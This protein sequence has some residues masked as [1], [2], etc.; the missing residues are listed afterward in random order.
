MIKNYS[1]SASLKLFLLIICGFNFTCLIAQNES[2]FYTETNHLGITQNLVIDYNANGTD[3]VD[4]S[5]ALQNAIDYLT[6]LPDGG[7]IIIPSGTFYFV[8]IDMKS[9]VHLEIDANTTII[10][11]A[12]PTGNYAIFNFG[13]NTATVNNVSVRSSGG[14]FTIDLSAVTNVNVRVFRCN[15]VNNFLLSD[16]D[17]LDNN[18]KFASTTMGFTEHNGDYFI[19]T[20]GVVKNATTQTAHYGYGLVQIQAGSNILYKNLS[21][22]GGITLRMESGYHLMN[23]LRPPG[24]GIFDVYGR[25]I[26]CE[27]GSAA[28]SFSPHTM[29]NGHVDV[30]GVTAVNCGF[31]A[32]VAFGFATTEQAALGLVPGY[33][34]PTSVLKNVNAVY[35]TTAQ[36]KPKHYKYMPCEIQYLNSTTLNPDGES[37]TGPS[38]NAVIYDA[39]GGDPAEGD[40]TVTITNV[41]QNGFVY[42]QKTVLVDEDAVNPSQCPSV[43]AAFTHTNTNQTFNFDGSDSDDTN[44]FI[45]SWY[46]DFGDG[47]TGTGEFVSHT[48]AASGSYDVHLQVTDNVGA[49]NSMFQTVT[50]IFP[51]PVELSTFKAELISENRIALNWQTQSEL[52]NKGFEIQRATDSNNWKTLAFVEGNGTSSETRNYFF[53]D[54]NPVAGF[55]YYRLKQ[56]DFDGKFDFSK[57]KVINNN[58]FTTFQF[59]PTLATNFI[60]IETK[61]TDD[62]KIQIFDLMGKMILEKNNVHNLDVSNFQNGQYYIKILINGNWLTEE[63]LKI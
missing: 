19:P 12:G 6:S 15:N 8:N 22:E 56:I 31:A 43:T 42:E 61:P 10:P 7:K 26:H 58:T 41:T 28:I 57:I 45:A 23:V 27:D 53:I 63:F 37:Y 25:N 4:D 3:T 16:F 20:N 55:N 11:T 9:N 29:E 18:T 17:V 36:L 40:Y 60:Q 48:Y 1:M 38:I 24:V 30:D 35:G 46:W 5:P 59:Y 52:N 62:F 33:F 32:R 34:A 13:K 50:G 51:L 54:K 44:G 39:H 49:T 21:G 2:D 47:T 14:N